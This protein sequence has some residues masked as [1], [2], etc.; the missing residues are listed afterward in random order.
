MKM[1]KESPINQFSSK[2]PPRPI[3]QSAIIQRDTNTLIFEIQTWI[4]QYLFLKFIMKNFPK[5]SNFLKLI[6]SIWKLQMILS[7]GFSWRKKLF[8]WYLS[9]HSLSFRIFIYSIS[10][11]SFST[12]LPIIV[13]SNLCK[14]P[15]PSNLSSL[16]Y[17]S[18]FSPFSKYWIPLP[19][20]KPL[21]QYPSYSTLLLY[22]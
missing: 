12:H 6:M 22:R 5:N 8:C 11:S 9:I 1:K 3:G 15:F 13:S 20:N 14:I 21:S 10:T 4:S 7:K 2:T 16:K 18:N 19:W 17:P